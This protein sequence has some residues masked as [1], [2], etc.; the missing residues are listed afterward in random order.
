MVKQRL[1]SIPRS[2]LIMI[3]HHVVLH[4]IKYLML[5]KV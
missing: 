5:E 2:S 1:V 4:L 3:W